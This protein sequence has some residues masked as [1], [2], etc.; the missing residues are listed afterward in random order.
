MNNFGYVYVH[1]H[2]ILSGTYIYSSVA[3]VCIDAHVIQ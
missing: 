1:V 3:M 2:V